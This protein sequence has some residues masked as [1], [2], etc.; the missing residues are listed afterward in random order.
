MRTKLRIPGGRELVELGADAVEFA[1]QLGTTLA[2]RLV[3]DVHRHVLEV[4]R[5]PNLVDVLHREELVYRLGVLARVHDDRRGGVLVDVG[6]DDLALRVGESVELDLQMLETRLV[7]P[8][9]EQSDA[10]E[11][12]GDD[13][14]LRERLNLGENRLVSGEQRD[15]TLRGGVQLRKVRRLLLNIFNRRGD[16]D[17]ELIGLECPQPLVLDGSRRRIDSGSR[18]L[19]RLENGS[20]AQ[21]QLIELVV[22]LHFRALDLHA[23]QR[24]LTALDLLGEILDV[25]LALLVQQ[26][27]DI[28]ELTLRTDNLDLGHRDQHY[29]HPPR[30]LGSS[31]RNP[32]KLRL[33]RPAQDASHLRGAPL[34]A[35]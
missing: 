6:R 22:H 11:G 3:R 19:E 20:D 23:I 4:L 13:D 8:L 26:A 10:V 35:P 15:F 29:D 9:D 7:A 25:N 1:R 24:D 28:E 18:L 5:K 30:G 34:L 17:R 2:D 12:A 27:H 32:T 14:L 33:R 31:R 16:L 21:Q